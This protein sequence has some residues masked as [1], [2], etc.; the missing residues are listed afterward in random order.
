M[1]ERAGLTESR[2]QVPHIVDS[3]VSI[4]TALLRRA[5]DF[6]VGDFQ[7][8]IVHH[9]HQHLQTLEFTRTG[10]GIVVP[11]P[12]SDALQAIVAAFEPDIPRFASMHSVYTSSLDEVILINVITHRP[13]KAGGC[14]LRPCFGSKFHRPLA[15]L[16]ILHI[17]LFLRALGV[18]ANVR[19]STAWVRSAFASTGT[20]KQVQA[21]DISRLVPQHRMTFAAGHDARLFFLGFVLLRLFLCLVF[22]C[23]VL[24]C[25]RFTENWWIEP[26]RNEYEK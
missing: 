3:L 11:R 14:C 10:K 4:F 1:R 16:V 5:R 24:L 13:Y 18:V 23:L 26:G 22:L 8:P 6:I 17:D 12:Q 2:S 9:N 7:I 15:V 19:E 20:V 25:L 21:F